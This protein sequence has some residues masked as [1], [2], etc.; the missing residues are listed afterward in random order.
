MRPDI[1]P[2]HLAIVRTERTASAAS[3]VR[4]RSF[5]GKD[6]GHVGSQGRISGARRALP[7]SNPFERHDRQPEYGL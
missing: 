1:I 2:R 4:V 6:A 5:S 3:S 7:G